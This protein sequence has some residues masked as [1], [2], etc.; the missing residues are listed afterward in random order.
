MTE[1]A[2]GRRRVARLAFEIVEKRLD[3]PVGPLRLLIEYVGAGR[4][5]DAPEL[6]VVLRI[7]SLGIFRCQDDEAV[8][9]G[10]IFPGIAL[11]GAVTLGAVHGKEHRHPSDLTTGRNVVV[12]RNWL[13]LQRLVTG[14]DERAFAALVE[15]PVLR[16]DAGRGGVNGFAL[17]LA[18]AGGRQK[19]DGQEKI[20]QILIHGRAGFIS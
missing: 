1:E 10:E 19:E 13:I 16:H 9:F 5:A 14:I 2:I 4:T 11:D 6:V 17:I 18:G 7:I 8:L 15:H 12:N 3:G 20:F